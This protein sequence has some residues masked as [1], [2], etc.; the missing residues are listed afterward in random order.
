MNQ[1]YKWCTKFNLDSHFTKTII[2]VPMTDREIIKFLE[3]K[4]IL[5]SK[6]LNKLKEY[7]GPEYIEASFELEEYLRRFKTK[8]VNNV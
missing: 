5:Q 7:C 2:A 6:F 1:Y 8:E 3:D 4:D